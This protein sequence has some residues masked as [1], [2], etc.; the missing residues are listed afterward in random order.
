MSDAKIILSLI[1]EV[2]PNDTD[3]LDEKWVNIEGFEGYFQISNYGRIK[4]LPRVKI[5]T[6]G[7]N[8]PVKGRI[9]KWNI[10]KNGYAIAHLFINGK[11]SAFQVHRLVAKHFIGVSD[12]PVNHKDRNPLNNHYSNLEYVSP[13][14]NTNHWKKSKFYPKGVRLKDGKYEARICIDGKQISLGKYETPEIAHK[15]Y[16]QKVKNLGEDKYV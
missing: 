9:L 5:D 6:L 12:F 4:S 10:N 14:E 11:D 8:Q 7:R 16:I 13:R 15:V 3:K 2:D 1:E